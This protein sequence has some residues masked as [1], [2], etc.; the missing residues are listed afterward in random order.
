MGDV[1][2]FRNFMGAVIDDR[3]FT[4]HQR[5]PGARPKRDP[6]RR[7]RRRRRHRRQRGLLHPADAAAGG[8]SRLPAHVRGDLRAGADG[9]R[10]SRGAGGRRR[11][12]WWTGP[13]RTRSPARCSPATARRWSQ[14]DRALRNAAGNYYV[15]DKPTGAV[16]GPAAVRRRARERHQR[17]GRARC[18]TC[19]AGSRRGASRKR[20]C[21][22]RTT[23]IRSWRRRKRRIALTPPPDGA[24]LGDRRRSARFSLRLAARAGRRRP[25]PLG[26]TPDSATPPQQLDC[27]TLRRALARPARTADRAPPA[28]RDASPATACWRVRARPAGRRDR[29]RGV[30]RLAGTDPR[31]PGGNAHARHRRPARRAL[32]GHP[33]AGRA[34]TRRRRGR[35]SPTRWRR[36][37]TWAAR[38]TT[39][40]R[41][42]HRLALAVGQR[43]TDS[44]GLELRRLPD[45]VAGSRVV[46]RLALRSRSETDQAT[47]RGDTTR[48]AAHQVTVEEGRWT[49]IR[50]EDCCGAPATSWWRRRCPR[51]ARCGRRCGRGWS[52]R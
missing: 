17:Q 14:A 38:W 52:R 41:P 50:A 9:A 8:G 44:A 31:Q 42:W 36:W 34:A 33:H 16:V 23:A 7:D 37:R 26:A 47:V 3:A 4:R 25:G 49:G 1:A 21:R 12:R 19:C 22:P 24:G 11:S 5:P 51:A 20:S 15:N 40:C 32:S 43:W 2:D 29:S 30:V 10:L 45:S 28:A 27:A 46:R 18:S 6:R 35:S 13:A 48:I 39:C